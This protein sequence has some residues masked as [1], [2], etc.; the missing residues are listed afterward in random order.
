ML[1][2]ILHEL[3]HMVK[4]A[5]AARTRGPDPADV[6]Q[7]VEE[8]TTWLAVLERER[9]MHAQAEQ[10]MCRLAEGGYGVC[11]TCGEPIPAARL[12]ALPFAVRCLKCQERFEAGA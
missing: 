2:A 3:R 11:A 1:D 7:E 10:A 9:D 12:R 6:A 5:P 4:Q 8:E